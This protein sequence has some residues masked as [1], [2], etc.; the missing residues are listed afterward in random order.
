MDTLT[1]P[2]PLLPDAV[3]AASQ[4]PHS[5]GLWGRRLGESELQLFPLALG[6]GSFGQS[7]DGAAAGDLIDRFV[8]L[9]GNFIDATGT[10]ADARSEHAVGS[11]VERR[12]RRGA[13]LLGTT[14]GNH[15]DLSDEP[16]QV[17]IRAVND[18]LGR[19]NADHLDLLSIELDRR[20]QAD[21]VLV[22]VDD[23][24][25]AGKVGG[26]AASAPTAD[27]LIEARVI[28]AQAGITPVVAV[29]GNYNL[30]HRGGYETD[31]ARVVALQGSGF[32]PRQPLSSGLL[33]GRQHSRQDIAR[34]RRRGLVATLPPKRWSPLMSALRQI[35]ADLGVTAP[36]V[37]LSW[38][39]TRP[40]VVA[41]IVSVSSPAQVE[42]AM[43]A[44][45]IQLTRQQT[46]ELERLSR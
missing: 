14:V 13:V 11:W 23:L 39:L 16:A 35:A 15:H 46:S 30:L 34:L 42:D 8:D 24:V 28:A 19:L 36:A 20:S 3:L 41:P 18:A 21:E 2:T 37:A 9:G 31:V 33:A 10:H 44:V 6:S 26:V 38:L 4:S 40:S 12:R 7:V 5:L 32:M 25:R 29:Q 17:I 27:Q 1:A 22:A 43:V 45:R